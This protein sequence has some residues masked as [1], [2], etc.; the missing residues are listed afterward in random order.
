MGDHHPPPYPLTKQE[1]RDWLWR[2]VASQSIEHPKTGQLVKPSDVDN[3]QYTGG[4]TDDFFPIY[5]QLYPDAAKAHVAQLVRQAKKSKPKQVPQQEVPETPMTSRLLD[6]LERLDPK[7]PGY[8]GQKT[9]LMFELM[10][11]SIAEGSSDSDAERLRAAKKET[12][13][14]GNRAHDHICRSDDPPSVLFK[15]LGCPG[16]N[17]PIRMILTVPHDLFTDWMRQLSSAK[18]DRKK[19]LLKFT[20]IY[21]SQRVK[22]KWVPEGFMVAG[23]KEVPG[24]LLSSDGKAWIVSRKTYVSNRMDQPGDLSIPVTP[25]AKAFD[26]GGNVSEAIHEEDLKYHTGKT[27]GRSVPMKVPAPGTRAMGKKV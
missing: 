16:G 10:T 13:R 11:E 20:M 12:R 4:V 17:Y 27:R 19:K 14:F 22:L 5:R 18:S 15:S 1:A 3:F 8:Q 6:Q 9:R 7:D 23:K 21:Q 24:S 25:T 26:E 2:T